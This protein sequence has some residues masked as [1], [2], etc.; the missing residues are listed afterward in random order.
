M[1]KYLLLFLLSALSHAQF[2]GYPDF[3]DFATKKNEVSSPYSAQSQ[4][5]FASFSVQPGADTLAI[6]DTFINSLV[7][8]GFW[9]KIDEAWIF[10]NK[11]EANA[12]RGLKRNADATNHDVV[13]SAYDGMTGGLNKYID[14]GF[15]LQFNSSA[16]KDTSGMLAVYSATDQAINEMEMGYYY[17]GTPY[18]LFSIGTRYGNGYQYGAI[19]NNSNTSQ[20]YSTAHSSAAF[21]VLVRPDS[22][23]VEC[24]INGTSVDK[25][26]KAAQSGLPNGNLYICARNNAGTAELFSSKKLRFVAIGGKFTP[27]AVDS[28]T[29]IVEVMMDALGVGVI[30]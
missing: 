13:F 16:L 8:A 7:L 19:N 14:S 18:N 6:Y 4:A 5:Y 3:G 29:N 24:Y 1:I 22:L 9:D 20:A 27:T 23:S 26:A 15:N 28:L 11:S 10:V 25:D 2:T 12:L 17:G 21:F 30:P